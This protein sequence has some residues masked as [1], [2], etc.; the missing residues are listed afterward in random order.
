[1]CGNGVQTVD[2]LGIA[3]LQPLCLCHIVIG[4]IEREDIHI[5]TDDTRYLPVLY[6]RCVPV[7]QL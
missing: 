7:R 2:N 4:G 5:Q 6:E 3:V 1:M